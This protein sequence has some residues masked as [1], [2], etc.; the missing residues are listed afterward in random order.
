MRS[1]FN[2]CKRLS[3]HQDFPQTDDLIGPSKLGQFNKRLAFEAMAMSVYTH[4]YTPILIQV[5]G[6]IFPC[7]GVVASHSLLRKGVWVDKMKG[8]S[9]LTA[10]VYIRKRCSELLQNSK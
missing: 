7:S 3:K 1:T 6:V 4:F 10:I 9:S 2:P 5:H 8:S